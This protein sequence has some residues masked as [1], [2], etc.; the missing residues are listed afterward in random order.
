MKQRFSSLDVK[1]IAHELSAKLPG[2]RVYNIY[3]LSS[4]SYL[5]G[6]H[7]ATRTLGTI[8]RRSYCNQRI[9]LV[10]FRAPNIRHDLLIDSGFR[11]HLTSFVRTTAA[12][13]SPFVDKLRKVLKT[14]RVTAVS[15]VGTDRV[16]EF[17]FSD[18]AYR[19]FLEFYAGGNIILTDG[20][21]NV[22]TLLRR[23]DNG[24]EHEQLSIGSRYDLNLR[25]NYAGVPPLTKQRLREGLQE[26]IDNPKEP[27]TAPS[28]RSK[29]K[30]SGSLRKSLALTINEYP[31]ILIE[32]CLDKA[33]ISR[34]TSPEDICTSE[35]L[36]DELLVA[37]EEAKRITEEVISAEVSRGYIIAKKP[38]QASTENLSTTKSSHESSYEDFQPF[39]P[40]ENGADNQSIVFEFDN[41]NHTV[42]EFFSSIEGQKLESRLAEREVTAKKK[43][44]ATRREHEKRLGGL[45]QVQELNI[46]KAEAIQANIARVEET[47]AAV[48]GLIAQG[49]DWVDISRFIE[50]EQSR[51]N[52]VAQ[53][54]KLP[55]KL[56]E[57]TV[58]VLLGEAEADNEM[59]SSYVGSDTESE[60]D[61]EEKHQ[62]EPEDVGET[63][64]AIDINLSL[65]S[66]VNASQYYDQK[67]FAAEKEEKTLKASSKALKSAEQKIAVE[68]KKGL[69][70]EKDILRPIRKQFWFE[71]FHYFVS[72]D[73]Y[74]VL[75]G[76]DAQQNEMLYR[77]YL[78]K[79]DI[80]VHADLNG[81][82]SVIIKNNPST[83]EAPIPPSTLSQAGSLAVCASDAWNSKAVMAAWWVHFDQ[84]SKTA[85]TG[86]YITTGAFMIRGKKNF[87]P[88]A[89]LI[90]GFALAWN[91]SDDSKARHMRNGVQR[92]DQQ[93][94]NEKH[95][96]EGS[97]DEDF[98]DAKLR[99]DSS[100]SDEDFP[101]A[102]PA[103]DN[104]EGSE[105]H[106]NPPRESL[107]ARA[108]KTN[109]GGSPMARERPSQVPNL[110]D[111]NREMSH[112]LVKDTDPKDAKNPR[113]TREQLDPRSGSVQDS[114]DT[115]GDA[116]AVD[117]AGSLA[118]SLPAKAKQQPLPRGKRTKAKKAAAKYAN[119]DEEDRELAMQI[120][121]VRA[122]EVNIAA[123]AAKKAKEEKERSDRESRRQH[124]ARRL[125]EA[126]KKRSLAGTGD[127][128]EP[129]GDDNG[130]TIWRNELMELDALVGR[131][132]S[133]DELLSA[134][135]IC[136]PWSA[137]ATYKYKV[138]LQPGS[139]KRGKAVK[140]V[141]GKWTADAKN[142]KAVDAKA[143]DT[144]RMWPREIELLGGIKEAEAVGIMPMKSCKIMTAGATGGK[145]A[146]KTKAA[147]GGRG[148]K[149]R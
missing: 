71:K 2:T 85:P 103:P 128:E 42:D 44:E 99:V 46:R 14:R 130:D 62:P 114:V 15:Q 95:R 118:S 51:G 28:K 129:A 79:G 102:T 40:S 77:R 13:P 142:P 143:E 27:K 73:K 20:S 98:P 110:E 147:R 38:A 60:L 16:I 76:K 108:P 68:L 21:L 127:G 69:N 90:M 88:P 131:P 145:E 81:A 8:S 132:L 97:D 115:L 107:K 96:S 106:S 3:D 140:E 65:S 101:D 48:N 66:W 146:G 33:G 113:N 17:Q 78:K 133:G 100:D 74:L 121:G 72:S 134:V 111:H 39:R 89:Q 112:G 82:P 70:Q 25:Q 7:I 125:A 32:H 105:M 123:E 149:K 94:Q 83:P 135:P 34:N 57:N 92:M 45:Q 55:L 122:G 84:V 61:E 31:P 117:D 1:V 35:K 41:F 139:T 109:N 56:H 18:G 36:L 54:I 63:R 64:L 138:K 10:K 29:E 11:C 22:L 141:L 86:E 136:A 104:D 12:A 24:P 75:G 87:L 91:I 53:L 49:M 52:P 67:K 5:P 59:D 93:P 50:Q 9:F 124:A 116:D 144:D 137:L 119:Q 26:T 120:L 47:V 30:G 43:L 19:L 80:Y 4:V 23:I 148:S 58:T 6:K 126:E 37:L